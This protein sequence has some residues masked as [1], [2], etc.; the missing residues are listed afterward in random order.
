MQQFVGGLRSRSIRW[1]GVVVLLWSGL[2]LVAGHSD[3]GGFRALPKVEPRALVAELRRVLLVDVRSGQ[4]FAVAHIEGAVHVPAGERGFARH[5]REAVAQART[6][7]RSVERLVFYGNAPDAE[8]PWAA[9]TE[10]A[11]LHLAPVA[12]LDAGLFQWAECQDPRD[13][14]RAF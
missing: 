6:E 2:V 12:V 9:A 8:R 1:V 13:Y 4:E 5:L 11:N 3:R 7:G 10:A 14:I